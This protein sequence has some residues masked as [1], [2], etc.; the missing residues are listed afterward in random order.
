MR[1]FKLQ[2]KISELKLENG[3]IVRV[4]VEEICVEVEGPADYEKL[5]PV[6][7]RAMDEGIDVFEGLGGYKRFTRKIEGR[8]YTRETIFYFFRAS[9]EK[10]YKLDEIIS[11][12]LR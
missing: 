10:I 8:L 11:K 6:I 7:G 3:E 5:V 2:S 4:P 1:I 9:G 12:L